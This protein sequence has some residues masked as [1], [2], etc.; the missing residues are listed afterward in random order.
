MDEH[1]VI[2]KVLNEIEFNIKSNSVVL[3]NIN[4]FN[5]FFEFIEE[6]SDGLHHHK[7][8]DVY[9]EWISSNNDQ[10]KSGPVARMLQEHNTFRDLKQK[11]KENLSIYLEHKEEAYIDRM[12]ANLSQFIDLLRSHIN[13]EDTILYQMAEK[14][15]EQLNNG[16]EIMLPKF[17]VIQKKFSHIQHKFKQL[18]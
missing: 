14:L 7:E 1:K 5:L 6:Y 9:F 17:E 11:A 10:L 15:N 3:S 2:L 12:R 13:R 18:L 8:E 16:D 4:K